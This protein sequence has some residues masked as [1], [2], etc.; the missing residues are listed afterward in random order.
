MGI[1]LKNFRDYIFAAATTLLIIAS[2]Y[3]LFLI[4]DKARSYDPNRILPISVEGKVSASPDLATANFT[5]LTTAKKPE[6]A[7]DNNAQ[8]V[9]SVIEFLKSKGLGDED[10]K[11]SNF[12]L[13][14]NYFYSYDYPR[15][16][17]PAAVYE[18]GET[19]PP[20][21]PV[22]V[23]YNLNQT[24]TVK[25]RDFDKVGEIISGVVSKGVNQIEGVSFSIEDPDK[26]KS[27]AREEAVQKAKDQAKQLAKLGNFRLGRVVN[28]Q[29][30]SV[31]VP[32]PYLVKG[33]DIAGRGGVGGGFAPEVQPG[34][35]DITVNLT[36]IFQIR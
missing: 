27:E 30:S 21:N 15:V 25:I 13:Y 29:E 19:C 23:S 16:P 18:A 22:I 7:Q 1:Q 8:K 26:L 24:L 17:C 10:I 4:S 20:K 28:I 33:I 11:T 3:F 32:Q 14:P 35:Q 12:N 34:S 6:E 9:N 5:V 36:V 31:Y 2:L